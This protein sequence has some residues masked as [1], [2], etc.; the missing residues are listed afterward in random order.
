MR[1][2]FFNNFMSCGFATIPHYDYTVV[3]L[4]MPTGEEGQFFQ[5]T[6]KEQNILFASLEN[7][8]R[9][10]KTAKINCCMVPSS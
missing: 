4:E 5:K 10:D 7:W 9:K 8:H 2:Q 6:V 1:K 3:M